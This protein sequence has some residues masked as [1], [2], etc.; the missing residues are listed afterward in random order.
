MEGD[1]TD[2]SV[3][4]R[5]LGIKKS[6][7][8]EYGSCHETNLWLQRNAT[9]CNGQVETEEGILHATREDIRAKIGYC[10]KVKSSLW[11]QESKFLCFFF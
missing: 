5:G 4:R 7:G 11:N 2:V 3:A 9:L 8:M 10:M 1:D 6:R